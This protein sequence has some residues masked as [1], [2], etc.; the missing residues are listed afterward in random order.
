[1]RGQNSQRMCSRLCHTRIFVPAKI[2]DFGFYVAVTN[3]R[4]K[5]HHKRKVLPPVQSL[6]QQ[7]FG[8]AA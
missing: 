2:A 1:M 4:Q 5:N 3:I 6:F 7:R 8:Q